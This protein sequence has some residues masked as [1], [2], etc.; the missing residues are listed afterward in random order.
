MEIAL[1]LL[2]IVLG[3]AAAG[4]FGR[5]RIRALAGQIERERTTA[6]E[7]VA[8]VQELNTG[9]EERFKNMSAAALAENNTSFLALAETKLSPLTSTLTEFEKQTRQL[10]QSRQN[11][12]TQLTTQ[13]GSLR[14]EARSLST[15]LRAP[16]VRGRWGEM[17]LRRTVETAGML[18][19]CDFVEQ[20]STRDS[21]GRLLRPDVVVKLPGGRQ[22]VVDAKAP[23]RRCSTRWTRP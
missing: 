7:K 11:A 6:E 8:L 15:A 16:A 14:D 17:Q 20:S 3:A 22:V 21:D 2:G 9:W 13:V 4:L 10:E 5:A 19:Y 18:E 1:V 12:Y 23:L